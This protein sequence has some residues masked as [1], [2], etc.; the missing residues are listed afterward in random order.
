MRTI[1]TTFFLIHWMSC[2][3][4]MSGDVALATLDDPDA[5]SWVTNLAMGD[6]PRISDEPYAQPL[7][8][9]LYALYWGCVTSTSVGYGDV[10]PRNNLE[11]FVSAWLI[12]CGAYFWAYVVGSFCNI[13]S[14][15]DP[16]SVAF[17]Q[18]IDS[19]NFMLKDQNCSMALN[20]RLRAYMNPTAHLHRL[21][22][23]DEL[24][25]LFSPQLQREIAMELCQKGISP[26]VPYLQMGTK[27]FMVEISRVFVPCLLS[28]LERVLRPSSLFIVLRGVA[29]QKGVV[30]PSGSA[31]NIDFILSSPRLRGNAVW[32][33]LG[34]GE[35][36]SLEMAD[37]DSVI[38]R[39]PIADRIPVRKYAV[40]LAVKRGFLKVA[41][42]VAKA[43][44]KEVQN[45]RGGRA[46]PRGVRVPEYE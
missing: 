1:L 25:S 42:A 43:R 30:L 44:A 16:H 37:M 34:F 3:F 23:Y 29:A 46:P 24:R 27:Y 4:A 36:I 45:S 14:N 6:A 39:C 28:P 17:K 12:I 7:L 13:V 40:Q 9:Y 2:V 38:N 32:V 22:E 31:C 11:V 5:D 26:S 41:R 19:V 18:R 8:L 15:P 35:M 33:A 21:K 10:G 20:K